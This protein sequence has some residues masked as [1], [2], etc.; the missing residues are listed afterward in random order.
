MFLGLI[1][2]STCFTFTIWKRKQTMEQQLHRVCERTKLKQKE[3]IKNDHP[4]Y[5]SINP[6]NS[7]MVS[8]KDGFTVWHQSKSKN[9]LSIIY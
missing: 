5:G 1:L 7:A 2:Q 3:N 8:I 4:F 9:F 6:T